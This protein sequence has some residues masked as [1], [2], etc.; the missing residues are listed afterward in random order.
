MCPTARDTVAVYRSGN[1]TIQDALRRATDLTPVSRG[2]HLQL[3]TLPPSFL[4]LS[5]RRLDRAFPTLPLSTSCLPVQTRRSSTP[6]IPTLPRTA[7][8]S[9]T[10]RRC[11]VSGGTLARFAIHQ[12][13][14]RIGLAQ[15]SIMLCRKPRGQA[16]EPALHAAQPGYLSRHSHRSASSPRAPPAHV[17]ASFSGFLGASC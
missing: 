13:R 15:G 8:R 10:Q 17:C 16:F 9:D 6:L 14:T 5:S 1:R 2:R 3:S 4:S 12:T 7:I 11:P